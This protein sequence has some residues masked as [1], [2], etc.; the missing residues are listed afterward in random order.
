MPFPFSTLT[1]GALPYLR[2]GGAS[3]SDSLLA[4][5]SLPVFPTGSQER[6]EEGAG[7]HLH[8]DCV[9]VKVHYAQGKGTALAL[10]LQ[11]KKCQ[12]T[13]P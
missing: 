8:P 10:S 2:R 11:W 13:G 9:F 4:G 5:E 1:A 6:E 7:R 12:Y 3:T